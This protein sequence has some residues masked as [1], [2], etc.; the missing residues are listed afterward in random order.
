MLQVVFRILGAL[1]VRANGTPVP[2]AGARQRTILSMLLLFA[3]RVVS[4]DALADA[5]WH[6][7]P[8]NTFVNQ[9]AICVSGLRKTFKAAVGRD[10]LIV[11]MHPGYMLFVGEHRIDAVEFEECTARAREAARVGDAAGAVALLETAL[12]MWRG[13][14]LEG[15]AGERVEAGAARLAELRLDAY[16]ELTAL[17]LELGQHRELVGELSAF[18][19]ENGLREQARAHLMLAQYR[20]GR[21]AEALE[22][23]R[24]G[25]RLLI[26]ELGIEPGP[27]LR[28]LHEAVLADSPRLGPPGE[29]AAAPPPPPPRVPAQLPSDVAAFTGHEDELSFLD[30]LLDGRDGH[31]AV[32]VGLLTGLGGVG[33]TALAVHCAHRVAARFPDGQLFADLRGYHQ[34]DQ[35]AAPGVVLERFL[36]ALGVPAERIPADLADRGALFRS[37]L[38]GRR[39]LVVL[40]NAR[41]FA[42]VRQLLP[43]SG[44]CG[45]LITSRAPMGGLAGDYDFVH[46][47]LDTLRPDEAVT[48]LDRVVGDGRIAAEPGE[49]ARLAELCDRL[50]LALRI[51]AAR[52]AARP[53]WPVR[54]LVARLEDRQRRLDELGPDECGVRAALRLSYRDL[55]ERAAR[56]YR[57]LGLLNVP[58]FAAWAGAALLDTGV[59][60]A[61]DLIEEL[62]DAQLL[63]VLPGSVA[64]RVR[65][66]FKGLLRLFAHECAE[67]RV[68]EAERRASLRR[69]FGGWLSLAGEA[70]RRLHGGDQAV[71]E[72]PDHRHHLP[73]QLVADLLADPVGWFEAERAAI[74]GAVEQAARSGEAALAWDL[75]MTGAALDRE[76]EHPLERR[77]Y[78]ERLPAAALRTGD[79]L[80]ETAAPHALGT[81]EIVQ[82]RYHEEETERLDVALRLFEHCGRALVRHNQAMHPRS[83]DVPSARGGRRLALDGAGPA[84][85]R[86]AATRSVPG[87]FLVARAGL[88]MAC[89]TA[90]S[91][92]RLAAAGCLTEAERLFE[93]VGASFWSAKARRLDELLRGAETVSAEALWRLLEL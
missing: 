1:D 4:V 3:N 81:L 35:P 42:Q 16:E 56:M 84:G 67:E 49:A 69:A 88:A 50:P 40:D 41:S 68:G 2:V 46:L 38:G 28:E 70:H 66:R 53:H 77:L 5:V 52:L 82:W 90:L 83:Y 25:R 15:V 85:D 60:E 91:G 51:A 43:G 59:L 76:R 34:S 29:P 55:P 74:V 27:A 63:D 62:V 37:V 47:P 22:T 18:I 6:G 11:T 17:R 79:E 86:L 9:I 26:E 73:E 24:E 78:G 93:E 20:C 32:P 54:T 61:E 48:L 7:N 36:L 80:A 71:V 21:R 44:R 14:A 89:V 13:P 31:D 12:G 30:R 10:D 8:P 75:A 58:D 57:L 39:V 19:R 33:K 87:R 64:G 65:Y 92:D 72:G 23:F 45:V